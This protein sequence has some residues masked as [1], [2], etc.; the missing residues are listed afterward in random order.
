MSDTAAIHA[1]L[2]KVYAELA[3]IHGE[4]AGGAIIPRTEEFRG[5]LEGAGITPDAMPQLG[6]RP[7]V[8]VP[9]QPQAPAAPAFDPASV[10]M[11][12]H[13]PKHGTEYRRGNYGLYCPHQTDDPAFADRKGYCSLP[14]KDAANALAWI[15]VQRAAKGGAS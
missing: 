2:H 10:N 4:L 13:C 3:A 8:F 11:A 5:V 7:Q 15:A 1:R 12:T 6:Q 14:G 9:P